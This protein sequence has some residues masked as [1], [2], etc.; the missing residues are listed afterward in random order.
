[1]NV[2]SEA[3]PAYFVQDGGQLM[4]VEPINLKGSDKHPRLCSHCKDCVF[5]R[6]LITESNVE[7]Q[8]DSQ[9]PVLLDLPRH[10]LLHTRGGQRR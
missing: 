4:F 8:L 10:H 7:V 5:L 6:T 9:F 3:L 2:P 1:M